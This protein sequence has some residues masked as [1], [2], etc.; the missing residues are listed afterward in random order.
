MSFLWISLHVNTPY[1]CYPAL[2][3]PITLQ[4]FAGCHW[5]WRPTNHRSQNYPGGFQLSEDLELFLLVSSPCYIHSTCWQMAWSWDSFALIPG[6]TPPCISSFPTWPSLIYSYASTLPNLLHKSSKTQENHL[7][8][9]HAIQMLLIFSFGSVECLIFVGMSYDKV[10]LPSPPVHGH[11]ELESVLH[12]GRCLLG[13]WICPGP[14]Q[15]I[16]LLR[17]PLLWPQKVNH[18]SVKFRSVLKIGPWWHLDQWNVPLCWWRSYLSWASCPDVGLYMRISGHPE[19]PSW[20]P[21]KAFSMFLPPLC[22]WVLLWLSSW[23]FTWSPTTVNEKNIWRSFSCFTLFFN[24]LLNPL[25]YSGQNAQVKAAFHRVLQ[26]KRT[27]WR[28]V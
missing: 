21:Q 10:Y 12:P 3:F 25:V 8:L 9:S 1:L 20:G 28:R 5:Q 22:G 17:L 24:P 15:V 18:S 2:T 13:V 6:C 23:S 19:D 26:K 16:L 14:I 7:L 27:V 11:H 4:S